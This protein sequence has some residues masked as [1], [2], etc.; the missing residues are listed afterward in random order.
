VP[1]PA[2]GAITGLTT[3]ATFAVTPGSYQCFRVQSFN[4]AGK[5]GWSSYGC[6]QTPGF[7]VAA[8]TRWAD[9]GVSLP[10]GIRLRISASGTITVSSG[11]SSVPPAGVPSCVPATA[12]PGAN[13]PFIAPNLPCWSLVGR[14][15]DGIPFG[16]GSSVVITTTAGR[17]YLSV[18]DNYF[19]GSSGNWTA[20]IKEGG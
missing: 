13:P 20:D 3:A 16:V 4:D 9:T 15:G 7:T 10:A 2:L 14:I 18:N 19:A 1:G 5:S 8:T 17:L 12:V 11:Y 6:I